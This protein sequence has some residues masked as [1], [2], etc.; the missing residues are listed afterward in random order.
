MGPVMYN[1]LVNEAGYDFKFSGQEGTT[2]VWF[3]QYDM[4]IN[5]L[6]SYKEEVYSN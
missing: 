6:K 2:V 5:N 1:F 3:H 4:S